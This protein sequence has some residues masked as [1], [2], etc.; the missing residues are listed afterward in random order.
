MFDWPTYTESVTPRST[1]HSNEVT[2]YQR[3]LRPHSGD[4]ACVWNGAGYRWREVPNGLHPALC[5]L[6]R[7]WCK[8]LMESAISGAMASP[9]GG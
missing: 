3:K 8:R 5:C 2:H 6:R 9:A 1:T 7:K 4:D